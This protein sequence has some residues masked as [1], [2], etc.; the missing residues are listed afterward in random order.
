MLDLLDSL[1][2]K[3]LVTVERVGGHARYGM[4]E[5]IRQFAEGRQRHDGPGSPCP[6]L[7]RPAVAYW[8]IWNGPRQR[9]ALDWVDV[10]FDNLRAGFRWAADQGDYAAATAIAANVVLMAWVLQRT[11]PVGW[12]EEIL[13]AATAADVP[14][15]PRLYTAASYCHFLGRI[16]EGIGYARTAVTLDAD[17]SYSPFETGLSSFLYLSAL[18]YS[19]RIEQFMELSAGLIARTGLA[20]VIGL[21]SMLSAL[22]AIGRAE[23]A[24]A[25]AADAV[26]AARAHGNP[27]WT[28]W[29]LRGY[30]R[31]FAQSDPAQALDTLRQALAFSRDDRL[32]S[33]EAMI[34]RDVAGLEAVN[35]EPAEA[36][37]LFEANLR[38]AARGRQHHQPGGH[39]RQ[40]GRVLRPH[41][42]ARSRRN[43]LRRQDPL[44]HR[45]DGPQRILGR[46][47]PAFRAR[48]DRIRPL[49]RRRGSH[50]TRRSRAVRPR[51]DPARPRR[52]GGGA[53]SE[54]P[55]RPSPSVY[56]RLR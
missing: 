32:L 5:T 41:R 44:R 16:E 14:Q 43:R 25:I 40:P 3:S 30:G 47:P 1:V 27:Y 19:G 50:G 2:R 10:E 11:E 22:P 45:H 35:G 34:A 24:R 6:L 51:A 23:E 26:A 8:D 21:T 52:V 56:R 18:F 31:A 17:P 15:L 33:L 37:A 29:A 13:E 36:L 7:R 46:G 53:L 9:V 42:T 38:L 12:A 4:L 20:K 49:R 55:K 28:A 48:R 54:C 39:A